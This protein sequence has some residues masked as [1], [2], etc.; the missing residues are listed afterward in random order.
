MLRFNCLDSLDRTTVSSFFIGLRF[1]AAQLRQLGV[2]AK[3][4]AGA[5][6]SLWAHS[7]L[8]T[9]ELIEA[10][11]TEVT[12]ETLEGNRGH[13][14]GVVAIEQASDTLRAFLE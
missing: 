10:D 6:D 13:L 5:D 7:S 12:L 9:A 2:G 8:S 1:L 14:D 4:S 3:L 11:G